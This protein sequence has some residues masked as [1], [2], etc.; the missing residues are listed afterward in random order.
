[1]ITI[2]TATN[3]L[4][5][6]LVVVRCIFHFHRFCYS[7]EE[8]RNYFRKRIFCA[9]KW[10]L[11]TRGMIWERKQWASLHSVISINHKKT[12][13]KGFLFF[14]KCSKENKNNCFVIMTIEIR[15]TLS[16]I[17]IT[18]GLLVYSL[19]SIRVKHNLL[20]AKGCI[21]NIPWHEFC[22]FMSWSMMKKWM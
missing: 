4:C 10:A 17:I 19:K 7:L 21:W 22:L 13:N 15:Y 16:S 9:H 20:P 2:Q 11:E 18:A 8:F 5:E 3:I 6:I 12:K 1:M 14:L